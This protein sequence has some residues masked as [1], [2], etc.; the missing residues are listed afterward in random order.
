VL[1]VAAFVQLLVTPAIGS[2]WLDFPVY[3]E[4]GKKAVAF[5]TVYD[6]AGHFQF[7][8][9]PLVA[10][11]FGKAFGNASFEAASGFFRTSMLFL[12][13]LLFWRFSG[14]RPVVALFTLALLWNA[15]RL[16]LALGQIN[17]FV[18]YLLALLFAS[19]ERKEKRAEALAARDGPSDLPPAGRFLEDLLFG[20]LFSLAVQLKL[21]CL[22]LIP[23][24]LLRKEWRKLALSALMLPLLAIGGV[25]LHSGWDFALAENRAWLATLSGS[26][27]ELVASEQ[28]VAVLGAAAKALGIGAGKIVWIALGAG[29]VGWLVRNRTWRVERVREWALGTVALF[30]P[31]VWSYW[32]LYLIPV[33]S[34]VIERSKPGLLGKRLRIRKWMP[35]LLFA[36]VALKSQHARWAWNGGI[37]AG[38]IVVLVIR[39]LAS[40]ALIEE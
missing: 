11:L 15:L 10:L 34:A 39:E 17:A 26:T 23:V 27:D 35:A 36:G 9:S 19:L 33:V 4:A 31:L 8:Y 21:F 1:L 37:L 3:W 20:L 40:V 30:N 18:L 25:A 12:W 29:W 2:R 32:I 38:V 28:N 7:K 16:D 22:V 24:L 14:R 6:I 13:A 5:Q